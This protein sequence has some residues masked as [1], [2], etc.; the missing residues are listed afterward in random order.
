MAA[1]AAL[2]SVAESAAFDQF[3]E[4]KIKV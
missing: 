3:F 2:N 4:L 1:N